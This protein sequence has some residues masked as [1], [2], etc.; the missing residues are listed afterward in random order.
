MVQK[1]L[2]ITK[3]FP[4][5]TNNKYN[6]DLN[7]EVQ[8]MVPVKFAPLYSPEVVLCQRGERRR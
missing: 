7:C 2:C 1:V 8:S 5:T 4:S 3:T 6:L